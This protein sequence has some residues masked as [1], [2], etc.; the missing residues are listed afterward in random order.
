MSQHL[1]S[2]GFI[3]FQLILPHMGDLYHFP[4]AHA[5]GMVGGHPG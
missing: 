3:A 1:N 2:R 5:V 4:L